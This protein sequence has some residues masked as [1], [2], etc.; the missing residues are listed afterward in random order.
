MITWEVIAT[1]DIQIDLDN[2]VYYLLA[3][4]LNERAATAV[5]DYYLTN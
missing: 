4:K 1:E 5:L 2:F 3:E